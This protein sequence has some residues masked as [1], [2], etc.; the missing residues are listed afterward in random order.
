MGFPTKTIGIV[1]VDV[2]V[3]QKPAPGIQAD[4]SKRGVV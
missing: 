4:G 1:K 3:N 2:E